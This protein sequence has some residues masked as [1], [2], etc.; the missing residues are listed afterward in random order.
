MAHFSLF[1]LCLF[2]F[3]FFILQCT[4][5]TFKSVIVIKKLN[6][7]NT[8]VVYYCIYFIVFTHFGELFI[9]VFIPVMKR[10]SE[11]R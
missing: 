9:R 11:V 1:F 2:L 5:E 6:E 8:E 10:D 3:A 7:I 4:A